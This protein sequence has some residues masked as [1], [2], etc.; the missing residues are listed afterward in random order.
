[1]DEIESPRTLLRRLQIQDLED[2]Y[3]MESDPEAIR[4]TPIPSSL[5]YEECRQRLQSKINNQKEQSPFGFWVA[6]AKDSY[7]CLGMFL[8]LR[9]EDSPYQFGFILKQDYWGQ[10]FATECSR[11]LLQATFTETNLTKVVAC[12][13][14]EN[15]ASKAVLKKLGFKA[16]S[17]YE[18]IKGFEKRLDYFLFE[19]P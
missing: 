1:M 2:I 11:A 14:P 10:G 3:A 13:A 15:H 6:L 12:T 7:D 4:Y 19:K 16:E 5:T 9:Q 8:L 17:R 18:N